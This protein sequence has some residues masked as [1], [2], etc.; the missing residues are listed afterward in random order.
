MGKKG[1]TIIFTS[2][3]LISL[4][5]SGCSHN[6]EPE[7]DQKTSWAQIDTY[8][9]KLSI[10]NTDRILSDLQSKYDAAVKL[11]E[12]SDGK[13]SD[14]NIS[15]SALS[16]YLPTVKKILEK[17][18][19]STI[20]AQSD[21]RRKIQLSLTELSARM[22]RV[23]SEFDAWNEN[24][25]KILNDDKKTREREKVS[26][27]SRKALED[28]LKKNAE[29]QKQIEAEREKLRK[30][31]EEQKKKDEAEAKA[32][33][34]ALERSVE[35]TIKV[36]DNVSTISDVKAINTKDVLNMEVGTVVK[37]VDDS[38]T[39]YKVDTFDTLAPT[40]GMTDVS[41]ADIVFMFTDEDGNTTIA[42][43]KIQEL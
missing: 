31:R 25:E 12:D 21:Y 16:S 32:K 34:D 33:Q 40:M 19:D 30:E 38:S 13:T 27:N 8:L 36:K 29:K 11:L 18:V 6:D 41:G 10:N 23:Q 42:T 2:T 7:I 4:S 9:T 5:L 39:I 28:K 35:V 37:V 17:D 26:E 14:N 24:R 15:R 22:D 43:A 1:M 3:L 20:D